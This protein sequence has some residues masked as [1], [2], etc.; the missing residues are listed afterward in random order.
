MSLTTFLHGYA[1][2][3]IVP[4]QYRVSY[5]LR[6]FPLNCDLSKREIGCSFE[7]ETRSN[8]LDSTPRKYLL[9]PSTKYDRLKNVKGSKVT[10]EDSFV[11]I[12]LSLSSI[13]GNSERNNIPTRMNVLRREN[14]RIRL[15]HESLTN[16]SCYLQ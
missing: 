6:M 9:S 14:S 5:I 15:S 12:L 16:I 4:Q 10:L 3:F 2:I 11:E 7:R 13:D 8:P 1:A